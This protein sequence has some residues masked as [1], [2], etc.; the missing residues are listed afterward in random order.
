[1]NGNTFVESFFRIDLFVSL[2][3]LLSAFLYSKSFH[4]NWMHCQINHRYFNNFFVEIQLKKENLKSVFWA[5]KPEYR[6]PKRSEYVTAYATSFCQYKSIHG[7]MVT[8]KYIIQKL[9]KNRT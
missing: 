4:N 6:S 1:M 8:Q 3:F 7:F 5:P 9:F 2:F